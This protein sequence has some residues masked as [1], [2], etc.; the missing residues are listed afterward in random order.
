MKRLVLWLPLGAFLIFL[1]VVA[2]GLYTPRQE[3][4]PSAMIGQPLPDFTLQPVYYALRDEV[5]QRGL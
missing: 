5:Q 1:A 4:V 3:A 2:A